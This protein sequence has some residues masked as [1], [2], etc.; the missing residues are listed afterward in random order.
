MRRK[1]KEAIEEGEKSPLQQ[2]S[3]MLFLSV[4]FT[5]SP[6]QNPTLH[7]VFP[8]DDNNDSEDDN[9]TS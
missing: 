3:S 6:V 9:N 5:A 8:N 2:I 7:A 4:S 1:K